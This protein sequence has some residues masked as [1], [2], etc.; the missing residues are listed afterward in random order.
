MTAIMLILILSIPQ[1]GV[2]EIGIGLEWVFFIF[3]PNYD[4]GISLQN[5]YINYQNAQTCKPMEELY[6]LERMCPIWKQLNRSNP[7]CPSR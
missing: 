7:C 4:F 5:L 3:L 1:L 2:A 6:D